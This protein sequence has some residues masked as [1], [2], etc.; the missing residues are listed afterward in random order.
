MIKNLEV[1]HI[2]FWLKEVS[3]SAVL[4]DVFKKVSLELP[5]QHFEF[6]KCLHLSLDRRNTRIEPRFHLC[7]ARK[8]CSRDIQRTLAVDS[9]SKR[10][11]RRSICRLCVLFLSGK[12]PKRIGKKRT[13]SCQSNVPGCLPET[14]MDLRR[15]PAR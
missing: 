5:L 8:W 11:F 10:G 12:L 1:C 2:N 3:P 6:L 14:G 13:A 7:K 15:R 4:D 9:I